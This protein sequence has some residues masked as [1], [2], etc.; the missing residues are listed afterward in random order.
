MIS[1]SPDNHSDLDSPS[2][3]S[4]RY[5]LLELQ[6]DGTNYKGWQ[7]QPG[8]PTVQGTLKAALTQISSGVEPTILGSGRTDTGVHALAQFAKV[9]WYNQMPHEKIVRALNGT[10][11]S[12]IRVVSA[13]DCSFNFHPVRDAINKTY[14]YYFSPGRV[15]PV[16]ARFVY[17]ER[18]PLDIERMQKAAAIFVGEYDFQNFR[19]MGTPVKSTVRKIFSSTIRPASELMYDPSSPIWVYEVT[20]EGFL[21]QMVRL[22]VSSLLAVGKGRVTEQQIYEALHKPLEKRLSAVAPPQGLVLHEVVY[23]SV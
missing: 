1:P 21:K 14:R 11:P 3:I 20:G 9:T 7:I 18:F 22:M 17:E 5:T 19:T 12:D 6:Y 10:L 2:T 16:L 15:A 8:M 4:K 13:R 23:K